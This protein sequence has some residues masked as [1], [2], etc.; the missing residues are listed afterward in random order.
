MPVDFRRPVRD[1]A[2][3]LAALTVATAALSG[4][5]RGADTGATPP[6]AAFGEP[7]TITNCGRTATYDAPPQRIVSMNDHVTET[8]I[9]MGVGDRIVGMGYGEK[10]DPL[11]ETAEQFRAIPS[12]AAEYPTY[13]QIRDL[14]PD[15]VVGG[16]RS[17]FDDK[18]GRGRDALE[19]AGIRTFLFSEYC[20]A[21]FSDITL[22]KNDFAQLG[23]LLGTEEQAAALTESITAELDAVRARLEQAAV[24]PVRTFFYDSGEAEPLSVGGVGIGNLIAEYAGADNITAEGP[25]P[26]F[27]TGWEVVGERAPEAIVVLDYGATSAEDKIAY[28]KNQPIVATTPAVRNDRFVV[29]PLDDFFESSR[30]VDSVATIARG[31]HPAAFTDPE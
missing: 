30:M 29:V 27:T 2:A 31:L 15:L 3:V 7:V 9:Q 21:G 24:A 22:L 8:L 19:Q 13:E 11:P 14:D 1:A 20:G 17:A 25:K 26:Y 12:L 28:L 16:M 5:S 23:A 4:C 18:T 6:A 10:D